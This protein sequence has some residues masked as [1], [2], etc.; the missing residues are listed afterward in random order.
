M[1]VFPRVLALFCLYYSIMDEI[2]V[3]LPLANISGYDM[4][5][6]FPDDNSHDKDDNLHFL[7]LGV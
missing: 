3:G 7:T 2:I 6:C 5:V 4:D 1:H